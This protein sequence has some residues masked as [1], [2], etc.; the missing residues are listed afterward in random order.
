[1]KNTILLAVPISQAKIALLGRNDAGMQ[2]FG[3]KDK[4]TRVLYVEA[5]EGIFQEYRQSFC[6]ERRY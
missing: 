5:I 4:E 2:I 1:L 3:Q 6:F